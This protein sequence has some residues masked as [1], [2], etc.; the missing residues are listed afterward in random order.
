MIIIEA[1]SEAALPEIAKIEAELFEAPLSLP[2]LKSL[3]GGPA[4]TGLISFEN[5]SLAGYLLAHL[6]QDQVEILSLGTARQ[7]QRQGHASLLLAALISDLGDTACFLEVAAG[8]KPARD[9]YRRNGFV[10]VG[11]R[12]GYYRRGRGSCDAVVMRRS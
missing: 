4:F 9:L 3:F 1:I 5:V 7:H 12:S 6:T 2:A 10:E 11:R 8:N